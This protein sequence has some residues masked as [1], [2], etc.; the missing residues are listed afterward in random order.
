MELVEEPED[1]G[2]NHA[3]DG[4]EGHAG[5]RGEADGDLDAGGRRR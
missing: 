1:E 2:E 4:G 5:E 3:D